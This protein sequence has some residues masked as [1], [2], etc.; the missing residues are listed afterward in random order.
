MAPKYRKKRPILEPSHEKLTIAQIR[1]SILIIPI[2]EPGLPFLHKKGSDIQCPVRKAAGAEIQPCRYLLLQRFPGC[3]NIPRPENHPITLPAHIGITG[4][5]HHSFFFRSLSLPFINRSGMKQPIRIHTLRGNIFPG[6]PYKVRIHFLRP[7]LHLPGPFR[8]KRL[9]GITPPGIHPMPEKPF[10][11]LFPVKLSG[12]LIKGVIDFTGGKQKLF[13][14]EFLIISRTF[15]HIRPDGQHE[16]H[17]L[18]MQGIRHR[19]RIRKTGRIKTLLPPHAVLPGTPVQNKRIQ[20]KAPVPEFPGHIQDLLLCFIPLLRLNETISPSRQHGRFSGKQPIPADD[21]IHGAPG[22]KVIIHFLIRFRIEIGT[23]LRILEYGGTACGKKDSI[24]IG[25]H[26]EG[27]GYLQIRLME[28]LHA[29][30]QIQQ[31]FL[32]LPKPIKPF[33]LLPLQVKAG[34]IQLLVKYHTCFL[35]NTLYAVSRLH[36][37]YFG[38]LINYRFIRIKFLQLPAVLF[39]LRQ[40]HPPVPFQITDT[41]RPLIHLQGKLL[42]IQDHPAFL[43]LTGPAVP[44][45]FFQN[46]DPDVSCKFTL[47]RITDTHNRIVPGLQPQKPLLRLQKKTA[48]PAVSLFHQILF[49]LYNLQHI[50]SLSL[51]S[52]CTAKHGALSEQQ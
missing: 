29:S 45:L 12:F 20:S 34:V 40:K 37:F 41:A 3:V 52:L 18:L 19:T 1:K 38:I 26:Q 39:P 23:I 50:K 8:R 33:R 17:I 16:M 30:P 49:S 11:H 21:F 9:A 10:L 28:I 15:T 32:R 4:Q 31:T 36:L 6:I 25:G 35:D 44:F 48:A 2:P 5:V 46:A 42:R 22:N 27:N 47:L 14:Q 13:L 43:L 51:S 24:A 7:R